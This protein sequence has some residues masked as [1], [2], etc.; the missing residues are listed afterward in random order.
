MDREKRV[1]AHKKYIRWRLRR[2]RKVTMFK[3]AERAYLKV[4]KYWFMM[5]AI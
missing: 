4:V 1:E 3:R 5:V 2:S